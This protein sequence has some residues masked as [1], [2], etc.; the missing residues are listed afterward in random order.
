MIIP[1]DKLDSPYRI[2]EPVENKNYLNVG[3]KTY[4]YWNYIFKESV[5]SITGAQN[6]ETDELLEE[7]NYNSFEDLKKAKEKEELKENNPDIYMITQ[8]V[9]VP[10]PVRTPVT[11]SGYMGY[12]ISKKRGELGLTDKEVVGRILEKQIDK[13]FT[14]NTYRK[15]ERGEDTNS[16]LNTYKAIARALELHISELFPP[17]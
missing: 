11:L 14:I 15:I 1:F 3:D 16:K 13:T 10:T 12:V 17:K 2:S 5:Y 8:I 6:S 7:G 9:Q 4:T